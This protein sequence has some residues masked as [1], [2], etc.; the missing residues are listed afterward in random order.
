[1]DHPKPT[2][3]EL[4]RIEGELVSLM[5]HLDKAELHLAA[6]YVAQAI[7]S[8]KFLADRAQI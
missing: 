7:E 4:A 3:D 1:M 8:L 6:A 2:E 5:K